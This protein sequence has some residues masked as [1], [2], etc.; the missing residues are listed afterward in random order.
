[1]WAAIILF[2][3][4]PQDQPPATQIVVSAETFATR[5]QCEMVAELWIGRS[6]ARGAPDATDIKVVCSRRENA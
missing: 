5:A 3:L 4:H 2:T 6:L 1:M